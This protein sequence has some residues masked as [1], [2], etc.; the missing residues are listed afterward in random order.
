[1]IVVDRT[2]TYVDAEIHIDTIRP[3]QRATEYFFEVALTITPHSNFVYDR[4]LLADVQALVDELMPELSARIPNLN[5]VES[6][7]QEPGLYRFL[8]GV[9]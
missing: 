6:G 4:V 2:L 5:W 7:L 3:Y 8:A 1:M 9:W